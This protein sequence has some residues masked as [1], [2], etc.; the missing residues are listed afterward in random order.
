MVAA[1]PPQLRLLILAVVAVAAATTLAACGDDSIPDNAVARVDEEVVERSEVQRWVNIAAKLAAMQDGGAKLSMPRP[2]DFAGCVAAKRKAAPK[3][4]RGQPAPTAAQLKQQCK[5][6]YEALRDQV[7]QFLIS[8]EWVQGEAAEQGIALTRAEMAK[9]AEDHKQSFP[10]EE[11]F[12]EFVAD[13]GMTPR[14]M[15]LRFRLG[16]LFS[17][18]TDKVAEGV[19][20]VSDEDVRKYYEENRRRFVSPAKRDIRMV[21][22]RKRSRAVQ[23]KKALENGRSWKSVTREFSID[24]PTTS[25]NGLLYGVEK[26]HQLPPFD[27]AIFAAERGEVVGPV[28]TK[29]GYYVF[30]VDKLIP[31]AQQSLREAEQD[32]RYRLQTQNAEKK[33]KAVSAFVEEFRDKWR[34]RTTCREGFI[35]PDC[36]NGPQQPRATAEPGE[37]SVPRQG[38]RQAP[39][40]GGAPQGGRQAPAPAPR[41]EQPARP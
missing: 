32:I 7:L 11:K 18:L 2:P 29:F 39:R 36:K 6:E 22:T 21:L 19:G 41:D 12:E 20:D 5:Q 26:G 33:Q 31:P 35:V 28:K 14:E 34:E 13:S 30:A 40:Q 10:S 23:A 4:A 27:K 17:K 9:L 3:P 37:R 25:Q 38:G 15:V 16:K 1:V 8:A 24:E